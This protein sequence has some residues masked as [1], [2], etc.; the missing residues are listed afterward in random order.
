MVIIASDLEFKAVGHLGFEAVTWYNHRL[1]DPIRCIYIRKRH[2]TFD[3]VLHEVIHAFMS[4][5]PKTRKRSRLAIIEDT[6]EEFC[7]FLP[8][9]LYAM[10]RVTKT[11]LQP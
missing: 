10:L 1:V 8:K 3:T 4:Y 9:K 11:I 2:V 7:E 5:Q 6:E